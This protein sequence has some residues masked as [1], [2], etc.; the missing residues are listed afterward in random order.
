LEEKALGRGLFLWDALTTNGARA[1][2]PPLL[3]TQIREIDMNLAAEQGLIAKIR[4]LSPQQLVEVEDFVEFLAAK[5][6][7]RAALDRLLAI[8]PTLK[9][10]GVEPIA[11]EEI[12]QEVEAARLERRARRSPK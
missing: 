2:F 4:G 8:A 3:V 10:A 1:Y 5:S 6:R 7:R 11:E 9:S 12:A